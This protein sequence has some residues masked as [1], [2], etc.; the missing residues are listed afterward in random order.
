MR[1]VNPFSPLWWAFLALL[2]VLALAVHRGVRRRSRTSRRKVLLGLAVGVWVISTVFTFQRVADPAFPE[3]TFVAAGLP[4][5]FCT[6]MT[7]LAVPAVWFER[8]WWVHPARTL[9]FFPGSAS[10]FLA[11]VTPA[12]EYLD[13]PLWSMNSLFYVV[14]GMNVVVPV[15][16][17]SLGIYRPRFKD[18]GLSLVWF[19]ALAMTTA[20]PA[21][22]VLR[23]W[24]EPRTNYFFFFDPE[25]A[26]IFQVLWDLIGV[27]VV[28]QV[29]L[30]ALIWPV[31]ALLFAIYRGVVAITGE[32]Y[33]DA[34]MP[35]SPVTA[36]APDEG[37]RLT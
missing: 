35:R 33:V 17:T 12:A 4:L 32:R 21:V 24:V 9:L 7:F 34:H 31:L 6:M 8:G 36:A 14:H 19:F 29:P 27:P 18:T 13:Q 28:Y 15:L 30:L 2:V 23:T 25:G 37:V 26:G 5:H 16:M 20:L 3:F 11:M 10:G 22:A 1:R